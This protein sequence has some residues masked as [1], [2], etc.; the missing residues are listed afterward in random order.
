MLNL[1]LYAVQVIGF[2][3]KRLVLGLRRCR[4]RPSLH[5]KDVLEE[6]RDIYPPLLRY[7]HIILIKAS[8][9]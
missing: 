8:L 3:G 1:N 7:D 9:Q 4:S 6:T 2:K 5:H